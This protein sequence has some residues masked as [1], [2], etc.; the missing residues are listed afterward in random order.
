[1]KDMAVPYSWI[2]G[3]GEREPGDINARGWRRIDFGRALADPCHG[4]QGDCR[5]QKCLAAFRAD[6]RPFVVKVRERHDARLVL[7]KQGL[8]TRPTVTP[9]CCSTPVAGLPRRISHHS[10]LFD[11][12]A[13]EVAK[14]RGTTW[15]AAFTAG[16]VEGGQGDGGEWEGE[17]I[18][19]AVGRADFADY[20]AAWEPV[21][22]ELARHIPESRYPSREN[23]GHR[24]PFID[25][26]LGSSLGF[27]WALCL[28]WDTQFSA[29]VVTS[30]S[31]WADMA[32]GVDAPSGRLAEIFDVLPSLAQACATGHHDNLSPMK[33]AAIEYLRAPAIPPSVGPL[34]S[35]R[36][37]W[38]S[39]MADV[40]ARE[41]CVLMTG[42]P[43]AF[44]DR[45]GAEDTRCLVAW[46][47]IHD[48]YDLPR[49]LA[50][51]NWVN[52]AL[53][54]FFA[55]F[56]A[57]EMVAWLRD[58]VAVAS[59]GESCAAK[60]FLCTAFVHVSNPRWAVNGISLDR[61]AQWPRAAQP[62]PRRESTLPVFSTHDGEKIASTP[63]SATEPAVCE[64][65]G[66]D[67][68]RALGAAAADALTGA[69]AGCANA[70]DRLEAHD[71][72]MSALLAEDWT[73]LIALSRTAW[74][75]FLGDL[76]AIAE[77]VDVG[78]PGSPR[79]AP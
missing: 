14:L 40:G 41:S 35:V 5:C 17:L 43:S 48:L 37:V 10:D 13:G 12:V 73:T 19:A 24:A 68:S 56:S 31:Y 62:Q 65:V 45:R 25:V 30:I 6:E 3:E 23:A 16:L 33:A 49:D 69:V 11:T 39:R 15:L 60:L 7:R 22:S 72:G 34:P 59:K 51:G 9:L 42:C 28:D 18:W 63:G 4:S 78:G 27:F 46:G 20:R 71:V 57:S 67:E 29:A 53:W 50:N 76:T 61:Q 77:W 1:M 52:A 74:S 21:G 36:D 8:P 32:S 58:T 44:S 75:T 66:T 70:S 38:L 54:A 47:V 64:C 2:S 79:A 26:G 55:G